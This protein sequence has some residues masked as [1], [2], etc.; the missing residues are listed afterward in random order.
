MA[1]HK[2]RVIATRWPAIFLIVVGIGVFANGLSAPFIFDDYDAILN[3]PHVSHL[4]PLSAAFSAPRDT[5]SAGR[6][7]PSFSFAVNHAIGGDSPFG[8]HVFN[9]AIHL[10]NALILF[11]IVRRTVARRVVGAGFSDRATG[12]GFVSALMWLVHPLN[13]EVVDYVTQ[14]TESMMALCYLGSVYAL[15]RSFDS[16]RHSRPWMVAGVV[17]CG[18]GMACKESMVTAPLMILLYDVSFR[19]GGF[20]NALRERRGLYVGL[21]ATWLVLLVLVAPGPRGRSA[22]YLS[23]ISAWTYLLNQP[24]VIL[25][26]FMWT[27]WPRDLILDY[28]QPRPLT[29]IQVIPSG[30]TVLGLMAAAVAAWRWRA[31]VGFAAV[32]C[33]V[34]LAPASS[35]VPLNEVGA[36]RRMYLPLAALIPT[37][38]ALA[39]QVGGSVPKAARQRIAAGALAATTAMFAVLTILRNSEYRDPVALWQTVVDRYPHAQARYGLGAALNDAGQRHRA[40]QEWRLAAADHPKAH[41]ALGVV[42][43]QEGRHDEAIRELREYLRL[44]PRSIEALDAYRFIGQALTAQSKFEEAVSVF[45]QLAMMQPESP[46]ARDAL[47]DAFGRLGLSLVQRRPVDAVNAFS[48]A[49]ELSP[50]SPQRHENLGHALSATGELGA[51]AGQYREALRLLPTKPTLWSALGIVLMESGSID[52]ADRCFQRALDLNANDATVRADIDA[53]MSRF[54]SLKS[55]RHED[56][57]R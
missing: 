10:L 1:R 16:E 24:G 45:G 38:V 21:A 18:C 57:K 7:F 9:L 40:I 31:P 34:T 46:T 55:T 48:K 52:E 13:S 51:A 3:N 42:A 30:L 54:K 44:K 22:G 43:E 41:F 37:L 5:P 47:A 8:Y 15:R 28:G 32:F 50:D 4:Q 29:L 23:E 11:G 39:F 17:T 33:F 53:A 12:I 26:Y 19:S 36:E 14:R 35:I 25:R 20:R 27:L 49:V 2:E 6:P 56:A